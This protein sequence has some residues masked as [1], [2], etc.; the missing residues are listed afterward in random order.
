MVEEK[1][2]EAEKLAENN[3]VCYSVGVPVQ[4]D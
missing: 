3:A 2:K 4:L 1:I